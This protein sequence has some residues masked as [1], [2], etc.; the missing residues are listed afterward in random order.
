MSVKSLT[1]AQI[2]NATVVENAINNFFTDK[3]TLT[4]K[5]INPDFTDENLLL[6]IDYIK[7]LNYQINRNEITLTDVNELKKGKITEIIYDDQTKIK[8]KFEKGGD[9]EYSVSLTV[10]IKNIYIYNDT[11]IFFLTPLYFRKDKTPI[12]KHIKPKTVAVKTLIFT[13]PQSRT[14]LSKRTRDLM[15]T[16]S[17]SAL[18]RKEPSYK[19]SSSTL[20]PFS[21]LNID[22]Q[23]LT[24]NTSDYNTMLMT[25]VAKILSELKKSDKFDINKYLDE[26][27]KLD[28]RRANLIKN[29]ELKKTRLINIEKYYNDI[30][31]FFIKK[32]HIMEPYVKKQ[33]SHESSVKKQRTTPVTGG[34]NIKIKIIRKVYTD[35]KYRK[36]IKYNKNTII[37]LKD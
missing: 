10:F 36:Y 23:I 9:K 30:K 17:T 26:A 2:Q 21:S 35:N 37:Y 15:S 24:L 5:K 13:V 11:D 14:I 16:Y 18:K 8:Y 19:S 7:Y 6:M 34:N 3:K 25:D 27:K 28:I 20:K 31:E 1:S 32:N 22:E 33:T 4:Y 29:K 12:F